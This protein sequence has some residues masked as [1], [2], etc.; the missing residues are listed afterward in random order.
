MVAGIVVTIVGLAVTLALI[1]LVVTAGRGDRAAVDARGVRRFFQYVVLYALVVV[2]TVGLAELIGRALGA[3]IPEWQNDAY[4]LAQAL[5]FV[6]IGAPLAIALAWWIRRGH[7]GDPAEAA[8]P[9]YTA[10]LTLA[11]LTGLVGAA[12]ALQNL[13][14]EAIADTSLDRDAAAQVLAWAALW[15]GHWWLSRRVLD[16][17]RQSYHLLLGSLVGLTMGTIGLVMTLGN[18]LDLMLRPGLQL[19]PL[20][21]VGAGV[22]WLLPGVMVWVAYWPT[23]AVRLP[24]RTLWLAYV[25]LIGV[26]GGLITALVAAS[27]LLWSALVWLV[28]D[29]LD[30][31]MAQHFDSAA[32]EIAAVL[33]GV[34]VWW[35]HRAALGELATARSDVRRVYEYLVAGI[36]L[37]AAA[38]GVG[39]VLVALIEVT[40]RGTDVG[41]TTVNTLLGAVTLLAVG[42]PLWWWHWRSAQKAAAA[43]PAGEVPSLARR[44][45]LVVLFGVAGIAAVIALLTVMFMVF[46]D[47][48]DAQ[49]GAATL[50][51][52]RYG[53][54]VLVASAAVS[55]YHGA[56]WRQD[57]RLAAPS[58]VAGP[59]HVIL[60]GADDPHLASA[61]RQQT[62]A[63][64]ES[65]QRGDG[66]GHSWDEAAVLAALA[67]HEGQEVLVI[68]GEPGFQIISVQARP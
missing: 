22:A 11:A 64:V 24:R 48:V 32:T 36:A 35:Y 27:R 43:D 15:L 7:R 6:L 12:L 18:S 10:Y 25:L 30:Q 34:L 55:A 56:I 67:G 39:T 20:T 9:L 38:A 60:V 13:I 41:I 40:T 2:V 44:I 26:G 65:W 28:G 1:A 62:G 57:A 63:T 68:A 50:R 17:E 59:R 8:S 54:G 3:P 16:A 19:R 46:R 61:V 14:F 42:A 53:L 33:I 5:T 4:E 47:L 31:T 29:R 51:S 66:V 45:Y 52:M 37:A 58:Q 49:L 23:A 21:E